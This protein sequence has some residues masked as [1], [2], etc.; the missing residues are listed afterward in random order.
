M[1][2]SHGAFP[3]RSSG[4]GLARDRHEVADLLSILRRERWLML[5]VF[6]TVVALG[7]AAALTLKTDYSAHS[8][9]LA[10]TGQDHAAQAEAE[11]LS[12]DALRLRVVRDLGVARLSPARADA[13]A[14]ASPQTRELI[15]TEVAASMGRALEVSAAPDS[16]V[17]R[18]S[19][20]DQ[21]PVRAAMV[22]DRLLD[23]YLVFRRAVLGPAALDGQGTGDS[24]HIVDRAAPPLEGGSLRTPA[25]MLAA[26]LAAVSALLAGLIR[27]WLRPGLPTAVTAARG[28]DLPVLGSA[29]LRQPA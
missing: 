7:V 27:G 6:L 13:Y 12:S 24:V 1:M 16:P 21:D 20:Q 25:L 4:D 28:L 26:A 3:A 23:D 2:S 17:V 9:V 5:A 10:P 11:I 22:L 8:S 29:A 15:E 18:V 19:Y 14:A